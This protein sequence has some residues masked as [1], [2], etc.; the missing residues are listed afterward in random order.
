[1]T[2]MTRTE[3]KINPSI[4]PDRFKPPPGVPQKE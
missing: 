1:M 4:S 2:T 3:I